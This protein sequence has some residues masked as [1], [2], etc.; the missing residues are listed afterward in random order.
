MTGKHEEPRFRTFLITSLAAVAALLAIVGIYG[1][2]AYAVSSRTAELG[3]RLALG[4]RRESILRLVLSEGL[5]LAVAGAGAGVLGALWLT[6]FLSSQLYGVAAVDPPTLAA[7][8]ALLVLV[9]LA[10]SFWPA[11]RAGRLDPMTVLRNE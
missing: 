9:A 8:A 1:V 11:R 3:I 2:M 6:R 10:A 7:T 4:A 5:A